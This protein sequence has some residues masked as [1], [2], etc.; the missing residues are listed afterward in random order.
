MTS[1]IYK[2]LNNKASEEEITQLFDWIDSSSDH[3]KQFIAIK[4]AWVL[5]AGSN[6]RKEEAYKIIKQNKLKEKSRFRNYWK[7]AAILVIALVTGNAILNSPK[8]K[9]NNDITIE[10][11]NGEVKQIKYSKNNTFIKEDGIII[12]KQNENEIIFNNDTN[13]KELKYNTIKI[14]YGKTFKIILSDSSIVHLNAGTTFKFPE[15]FIAS[16]NR[17]VYLTGEAFFEVTK[18]KES[19]FIVHSENV[20]I[21]VLGTKFNLSTYSDDNYSHSELLEGSVKISSSSNSNIYK[22]LEPNQ[23]AVWNK[24]TNQ[25]SLKTVKTSDYIAWLND[26]IIFNN[27]PF[28][29]L[30]KKLERAYNINIINENTS[31]ANQDFT[32]TINVK[33]SSV[34]SLFAL[35]QLD[36]PFEYIIDKN[37]IRIKD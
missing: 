18:N 27:M 31:L 25:F 24:K 21:E 12:G 35:L 33:E 37:T 15:K 22:I 34:E 7:Y 32:G 29:S 14:P 23:Q 6:Y 36:T 30:S 8:E 2:Y 28:S 4:S 19:P 17:D 5:T 20:N 26:E 10:L 13:T 3:K 9:L 1:L 16:R 11:S